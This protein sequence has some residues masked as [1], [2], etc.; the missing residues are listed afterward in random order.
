MCKFYQHV[1]IVYRL[2]FYQQYLKNLPIN[3]MRNFSE[4]IRQFYQYLDIVYI[5]VLLSTKYNVLIKFYQQLFIAHQLILSTLYVVPMVLMIIISYGLQF[6][7][8]NSLIWCISSFVRKFVQC[9]VS[10]TFFNFCL[11]EPPPTLRHYQGDRLT[12]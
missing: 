11:A 6:S 4:Y 2:E 8:V 1:S 3:F 7:S 12:T 9:S 5:F 10:A